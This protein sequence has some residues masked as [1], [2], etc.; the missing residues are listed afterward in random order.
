[1][2]INFYIFKFSHLTELFVVYDRRKVS[3]RAIRH[4]QT[5]LIPQGFGALDTVTRQRTN[6]SYTTG[7]TLGTAENSKHRNTLLNWNVSTHIAVSTP[8]Q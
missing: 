5:I 7:I 8:I 2:K 6:T 3:I 1:M 4:T